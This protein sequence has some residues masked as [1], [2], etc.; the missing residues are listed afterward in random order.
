[1]KAVANAIHLQQQQQQLQSGT[2]TIKVGSTQIK[3]IINTANATAPQPI[4]I[5]QP[6][7][8]KSET[9]ETNKSIAKDTSSTTPILTSNANATTTPVSGQFLFFSKSVSKHIL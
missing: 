6:P 8:I 3:P 1:M 5:P 7:I 2:P 4:I 9:I